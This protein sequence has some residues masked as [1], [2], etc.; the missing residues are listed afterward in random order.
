MIC[1]KQNKIN[2]FSWQILRTNQKVYLSKFS[3]G[4]SCNSISF[5]GWKALAQC[6]S[7]S[8]KCSNAKSH[9]KHEIKTF[10][11]TQWTYKKSFKHRSRSDVHKQSEPLNERALDQVYSVKWIVGKDKMDMHWSCD[12]HPPCINCAGKTASK[13]MTR[14]G[15]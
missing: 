6:P 8:M 11:A 9:H 13:V 7:A 15:V 14:I 2:E 4:L 10:S 3:S 12:G 1:P 5:T